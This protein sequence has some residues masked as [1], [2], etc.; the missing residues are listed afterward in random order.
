MENLSQVEKV[1]L[2]VL[3]K[4]K[5]TS[6]DT[7]KIAVICKITDLQAAVAVQLLQHRNL[8]VRIN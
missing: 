4:G 3:N 8:I 5:A 6:A 1:V 7:H 2:D